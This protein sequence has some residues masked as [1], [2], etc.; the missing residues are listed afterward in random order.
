[1]TSSLYIVR[2]ITQ[3]AR[4]IGSLSRG[5][6]IVTPEGGED[7]QTRIGAHGRVEIAG[8]I[9]GSH[10]HAPDPG[11]SRPRIYQ[12]ADDVGRRRLSLRQQFGGIRGDAATEGTEASLSLDS[13][14][15]PTAMS[16]RTE[17]SLQG[18]VRMYRASA[19]VRDRRRGLGLTTRRC[20][21]IGTHG[22]TRVIK[23]QQQARRL[24]G[25]GMELVGNRI[26]PPSSL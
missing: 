24:T 8:T 18:Y 10:D 12:S 7:R 17:T 16:S 25:G 14:R 6:Y 23:E 4:W 20:V 11:C 13:T 22:G 21:V 26:Q 15:V 9:L 3:G 2:L 5:L 1:M 19:T